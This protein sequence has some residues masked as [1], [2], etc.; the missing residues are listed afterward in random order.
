MVK[1]YSNDLMKRPRVGPGKFTQRWDYV[2]VAQGAHSI[3][4]LEKTMNQRKAI[5][6]QIDNPTSFII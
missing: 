4:E 5:W 6:K 1:I 2:V 3:Y